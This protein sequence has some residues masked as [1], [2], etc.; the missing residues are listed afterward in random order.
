MYSFGTV[1]ALDVDI[2][3]DTSIYADG[4]VIGGLQSAGPVEGVA[5]G[6]YLLVGLAVIDDDNEGAAIDIHIF[7]GEPSSIADQAAFA[8]TAAD[9][10]KRV[11][12]VA[13]AAGDYDT[14]NSIKHAYKGSLET[15]ITNPTFHFYVV[16]DGSTPTYAADKTLTVRFFVIG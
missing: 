14:E 8:P 13:V 12:E 9:M 3:P 15:L 7:D 10:K 4:D 5:G 16:C 1:K 6:G 11:R 2:T